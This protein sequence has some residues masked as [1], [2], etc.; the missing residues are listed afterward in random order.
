MAYYDSIIESDVIEAQ[1]KFNRL[2]ELKK[3]FELKEKK[4]SKTISQLGYIHVLIKKIAIDL[5]DTFAE[6][7][8]NIKEAYEYNYIKN[9]KVY[10]YS[11]ADLTKESAQ[12]FISWL[13]KWAS[14]E[15]D[16][17]LPDAEEYKVHR[18]SI[19]REIAK[20]EPYL[21]GRKK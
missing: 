19:D 15:F 3:R 7:K 2:V 18:F 5:G 20:Y 4:Q 12:V 14:I 1:T 16:I 11:F 21:R 17:V 13:L 9:G 6:E 10:E 8:S